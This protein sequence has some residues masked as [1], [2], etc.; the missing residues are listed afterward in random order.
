MHVGTVVRFRCDCEGLTYIPKHV[1][2][3]EKGGCH[4]GWW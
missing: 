4:V 3:K 2:C 1:R